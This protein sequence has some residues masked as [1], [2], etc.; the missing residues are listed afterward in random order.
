MNAVVQKLRKVRR[1]HRRQVQHQIARRVVSLVV[2]RSTLSFRDFYRIREASRQEDFKLTKKKKRGNE[3]LASGAKLKQPKEVEIKVDMAYVI[4]GVFK[5]RR[6]KTHIL[7]VKTDIEKEELIEKAIIKHSN[8][9]Q[10]FDR[11]SPY[12]LLYPDLRSSLFQELKKYSL[13]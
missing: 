12:V 4:D 10:S 3:A 1:Q 8:F 6:N 2:G 9:D 5:I 11:V 7:K 13:W